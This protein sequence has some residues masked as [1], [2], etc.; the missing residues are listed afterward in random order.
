MTNTIFDL[1]E[2][3]VPEGKEG[4]MEMAAR[5]PDL[6]DDSWLNTIKDYGKTI[7]K[8]TVEGVSKL[9]R[10]MGPLQT[11]KTTEEELSA[12]T[13]NLEE[14]LPTDEGFT[15]KA[16]RRGLKE[17]PS[18]MAM[19]PGSAVQAGT[20]S[21]LA[22]FAGE[23]AKELGAPEWAQA[24]AEITAFVGPDITKKLIMSG[25]DKTLIS[26]AKKMGMTDEQITPLLQPDF[27]KKWL[28]KL[29]PKR[30][31]T[32][33]ALKDT[34]DALSNVYSQV[35]KSPA[36]QN[37]ISKTS[38]DV[39][40]KEFQTIFK[41][42]PSGVRDIIKKDLADLAS[43]PI[44]GDTLINFYSDINHYLGKDTKQLSLLKDPIKRA[45]GS[46]SPELGKDFAMTNDLFS[47][48][49]DIAGKLKPN[50]V[51]DIVSSSEALGAFTSIATGYYPGLIPII[52]HT[53]AK[54]VAQQLLINPRFQQLSKKMIVAMDQNKIGLA[55]KLVDQFSLE[56]RKT[57]PEL[58]DKM[59]KMTDE[60]LQEFLTDQNIE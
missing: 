27:K 28:T 57:S 44:T 52:G 37:V 29:A 47:K 51:S 21:I 38:K 55:K 14:L 8:G 30:G 3:D 1:V 42:M 45:L 56:V 60:E 31:S 36:A 43:K 20:R 22:G 18:M 23:G 34:K 46:I 24:A 26:W 2:A 40:T 19:A 13:E 4:Y 11:G 35:Q 9:G 10:V 53:V 25:K 17:A 7:L 48:Y 58:A 6:K 49:Y 5:A 41:D 54:K 32:A 59:D 50:L 33:T 12:Q 39:L 15:Q 16:L